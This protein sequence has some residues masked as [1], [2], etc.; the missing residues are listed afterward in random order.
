MVSRDLV[1]ALGKILGREQ[2]GVDGHRGEAVDSVAGGHS[3]Y[4]TGLGSIG[5]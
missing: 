1:M 5:Y 4:T 3:G 2:L